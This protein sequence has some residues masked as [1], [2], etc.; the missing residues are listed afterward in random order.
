MLLCQVFP[1]VYLAYVM[2]RGGV[3]SWYPYPF[4]NPALVGGYGGV[5]VYVLGIVLVFFVG[6]WLLLILSNK[7]NELMSLRQGSISPSR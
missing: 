6:S 5:T 7:L 3:I 1:L 4:L 2:T